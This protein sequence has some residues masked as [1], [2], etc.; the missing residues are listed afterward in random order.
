[1]NIHRLPPEYAQRTIDVALIG[2]GG[3]GSR[4]LEQLVNLNRALLALGHPEGIHVTVFDDD[5]VSESNVGRQAFYPCDV[6]QYKADVLVN[7][8]NMAM[9]DTQWESMTRRLQPPEKGERSMLRPF[10]LV[11]GAVDNRKARSAIVQSLV[12]DKEVVYYLDTGNRTDDG[13]AILGQVGG[14]ADDPDRL[15]HAGELFPELLDATLDNQHDDAPSCSLAEALEKQALFIN[16]AISLFAM[17]ILWQLF[18]TGQ[19][20]NHGA[21]VNLQS[22]HVRPLP[23]CQET[24][25]RFGVQRKWANVEK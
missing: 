25:K 24:W 7:R 21:F 4:L 18:T 5:T 3:T 19:I 23:V 2:A 9:G 13:Q 8:I 1:M 11:I 15:P 16:P 14:D 20:Q 6:G 22:G 12:Q 17:N 10:N